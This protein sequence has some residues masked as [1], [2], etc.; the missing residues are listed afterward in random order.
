[1]EYMPWWTEE[2]KKLADDAQKF[3]DEVLIP[4]CEKSAWK[5]E[6][7]WEAVR[8]I[9]KKGWMGAQIPAR[10]G[11]KL[12]QWG[13]TGACIILEEI[14]R[15]G[16]VH[17]PVSASMIGGIHQLVHD[18]N[19]E[20]KN[21]WL[22]RIAHGELLG[23][24]VMTEPYA[25][26][27]ISSIETTAVREGDYYIVKGKKRFQTGASAADLYT[28]YVR[29][30]SSPEDKTKFRHLTAFIV[31]KGMPGFSIERINDLMAL[32]GIYNCY[33]NFDNVKVPV[34]NR[35]G[36][37]GDGWSI[38]MSGLNVER[39]VVSAEPLGPMREAIRYAN[40]HLQRRVQFGRRTGEMPTN[41]F[42]L[43][44][45]IALYNI[46]R[47]ITYYT[48]YC[49]D[50][51]REIP[52]EAAMCKLFNTRWQL[53][54]CGEA[55][56][57][58]GGNGAMKYYPVERFFRDAKVLQI[59]AGTDE[60]LKMVL[61]R[62]GTRTLAKDLRVPA[63]AIDKDTN[64]PV[65]L[66]KVP[67]EVAKSESDILELLAHDY[68]VNPG[69]HMTFEDLKERLEV[70][71]ENLNK[72]IENLE[73]QGLASV[74]RGNKANDIMARISFEGLSKTQVKDYY[75]YI[76]NWADEKDTF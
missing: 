6:Y 22:P 39:T 57:V 58:M 72:Y 18:G 66:G 44:E 68:K 9:G 15:A 76:P 19:E 26:T 11:G 21:R 14:S 53:E 28:T 65:P 13:V 73:K 7:P 45:M 43:S 37:E 33:L 5:M 34:A 23:S 62:M 75:R 67:R 31:E 52:V 1:M 70:S 38:M 4:L 25:G 50:L 49:A 63:R 10:Y 27:D 55:I 30:S 54:V 17:A 56:Q 8:A 59:A 12:D 36:K 3:T 47:L 24:I 46:S 35:L 71:D 41:Q 61:Y 29:T 32:D 60:A 64:A 74:Y 48:A 20:Q 16:E 42:K 40:Q 2:Q 69:L 51:G